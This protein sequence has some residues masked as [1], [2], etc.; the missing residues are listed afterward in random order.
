M[1]TEE[2]YSLIKKI[3]EQKNATNEHGQLPTTEKDLQD[4]FCRFGTECEPLEDERNSEKW[5]QT[6][7]QDLIFG[8]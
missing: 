4:E 5:E 2:R 6:F 8:S 1:T 3:H 7:L